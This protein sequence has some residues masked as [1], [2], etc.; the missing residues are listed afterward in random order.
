MNKIIYM[1][2]AQVDD[3]VVF[4]RGFDDT[5]DLQRGINEA[6]DAVGLIVDLQ[7]EEQSLIHQIEVMHVPS[8]Q[9]I[10]VRRG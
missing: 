6:E 5:F 1:L 10:E 8:E 4:S 2:S 7:P 3:R 9:K